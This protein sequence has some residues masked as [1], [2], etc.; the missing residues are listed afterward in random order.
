MVNARP[1]GFLGS[2][3]EVVTSALAL[4]PMQSSIVPCR[5]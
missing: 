4:T 3:F 1:P 2:S 5:Q